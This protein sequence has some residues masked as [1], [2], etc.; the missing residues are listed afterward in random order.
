LLAN[1]PGDNSSVSHTKSWN[2]FGADS[3]FPSP[4]VLSIV[5]DSASEPGVGDGSLGCGTVW[6]VDLVLGASIE[7]AFTA[8]FSWEVFLRLVDMM[9]PDYVGFCGVNVFAA[10]LNRGS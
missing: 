2:D 10:E 8:P 1:T 4:D 6:G 5:S 3:P 9:A 7:A